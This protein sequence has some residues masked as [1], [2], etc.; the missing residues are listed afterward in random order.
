MFLDLP[1]RSK[2]RPRSTQPEIRVTV[3]S[4]DFHVPHHDVA[5]YSAFKHFLRHVRPDYHIIAGDFLDTDKLS[6]SLQDS[7]EVG[8]EVELEL[9][10]HLLDEIHGASPNTITKFTTG[11]VFADTDL[12]DIETNPLPSLWKPLPDDVRPALDALYL[13]G[14]R[15]GDPGRL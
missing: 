10:N 7:N 12:D 4:S 6:T 11:P 5:A 9:A 13:E 2:G 15:R 1:K 3:V 8:S 14:G